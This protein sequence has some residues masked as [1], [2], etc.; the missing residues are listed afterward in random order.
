MLKS[1]IFYIGGMRRLAAFLLLA[2]P[3]LSVYAE[4]DEMSAP[5]FL[6]RVRTPPTVKT[7]AKLSG[8]VTNMKRD[9]DGKRVISKSE[10][11]LGIRFA[12]KMIFDQIVLGNDEIYSVGQPYSPG[13]GGASVIKGGDKSKN[14]LMAI[15]GIKPEDLTMSFIFWEFVKELPGESVSLVDCRVFVLRSP[16]EKELARVYIGRDN[17]FPVKVEWSKSTS[18]NSFGEPVRTLEVD[19]FKKVHG[20]YLVGSLSFYGPGWRTSVVFDKYDAGLVKDGVPK[21]I[22]KK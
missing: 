2:L 7:W 21:D 5:Q 10:I 12:S 9:K 8:R 1:K 20:L 19:S 3:L 13:E 22:F 18:D 14:N 16:D 15:F 11:Y 6:A 17:F 4:G